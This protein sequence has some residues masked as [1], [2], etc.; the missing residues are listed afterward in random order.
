M[1]LPGS[2]MKFTREISIDINGAS[3]REVQSIFNYSNTEK[4]EFSLKKANGIVTKVILKK[5]KIDNEENSVKGYILNDGTKKIGYISLP[6]FYTEWETPN[7]N[8]CANDVAKEIVKLKESSIEGLI[9]DLR[10]NGGG[11]TYEALGLMGI[12]I[13]EGPLFMKGSKEG[14]PLLMKDI[15]RGTIYDGPLLVMING[16]SASASEIVASTLQDYRR[17]FIAGSNSFGKATEQILIAVHSGTSLVDDSAMN[18]PNF[19]G[20]TKITDYKLYRVTGSSN[21]LQGVKPDFIFPEVNTASSVRESDLPNA[22]PNDRINKQLMY[23]VF[24]SLPMSKLKYNSQQRI[25]SSETFKKIELINKNVPE[26]WKKSTIPAPLTME[27]FRKRYLKSFQYIKSIEALY[28]AKD[29][30]YVVKQHKYDK[31]LYEKKIG[32]SELI[33]KTM[34]NIQ[35]D[36]Y[37]QESFTILS[38]YL[39]IKK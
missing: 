36:Y 30:V 15:N 34:E 5:E 16:N 19:M 1:D 37:I 39:T 20:M 8:G 21:Q 9:L 4:L 24:D 3:A 31:I 2:R 28:D 11:S 18:A 38:D 10:D 14:K 7:G 26:S 35:K 25:S 13:D 29:T 27:N 22:L 6:G 32:D 23:T 12:F 17:A 33:E